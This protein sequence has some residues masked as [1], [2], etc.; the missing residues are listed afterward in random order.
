MESSASEPSPGNKEED[1]E[2]IG[3]GNKL[4]LVNLAEWFLLVKKDFDFFYDMDPSKMRVLK[5]K[6]AQEKELVSHRHIFRE[7]KRQNCQIKIMMYCY[8]VT[9]SVPAS[10]ASHST[11]STSSTS[12]SLETARSTLHF[13]LILSL[14]NRKTTRMKAFKRIQFHLMN[15]K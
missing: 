4:A 11:S 9:P 8:K 6:Q 5:L 7:M 10:P 12:V 1:V 2:A 15:S 3:L 14:L 13:L